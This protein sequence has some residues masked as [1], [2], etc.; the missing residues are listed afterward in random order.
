MYPILF[1][2]GPMEIRSYGFM[3]V[4]GIIAATLLSIREAKFF[5]IRKDDLLDLV[6]LII[7]TSIIGARIIFVLMNL[8]YYLTHPNQLFN[9]ANGGLSFHGGLIAG[10]LSGVLW[11]IIRRKSILVISD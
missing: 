2:I 8:D 5:D 4:I 10:I 1:T 7:I 11:C 6:I 3:M 9:L